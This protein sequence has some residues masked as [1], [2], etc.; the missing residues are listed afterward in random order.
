V[1]E[2]MAQLQELSDVASREFS[3]EK[4]LDKMAADW[5]GLA[6]ELGA[7][8]ATG[9]YILKGGPVDEAQTLLD[10]HIVKSQAMTASPFAKPFEARLV[11][12]E[13][14]LVRFQDILDQWLKCQGKWIYLEPIFSAEMIM[15]QIPT[16]GAA[17]KSM[18][19][20]WHAIMDKVVVNPNM[21]VVADID[22]LLE[23]LQAANASLDVVEKGLN[24][25]LDTKKM[26]F[27]RFY[28]LSN[29]ELLEILSEAKD[30][31]KIQPFVR[32]IFEAMKELQFEEGDMMTAMF[33]VEGEKV[34][35]NAGVDP[36]QSNAVEVWLGEVEEAMM[37]ALRKQ[38]RFCRYRVSPT[39]EL[40]YRG[41]RRVRTQCPLYKRSLIV[42]CKYVLLL[43]Y[44]FFYSLIPNH[45]KVALEFK[46]VA[47]K[48]DIKQAGLA[49][50]AYAGTDRNKW[51][52]EW[53]GQ[54]VL[55]CSQIYW[56]KEAADALDSE[57]AK[58]LTKYGQQCTQQL[59]DIVNLVRGDLTKL[60]RSTL[61]AL[62]TIDVHARDVTVSMGEEGVSSTTDFKWQSQLRYYMVDN[63][64]Q[65]CVCVCVCVCACVCVCVC[66]SGLLG[67]FL[68]HRPG[69]C[70]CRKGLAFVGPLI[71]RFSPAKAG[72]TAGQSSFYCRPRPAAQLLPISP[73]GNIN[74]IA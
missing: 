53:P 12:W 65:V 13:R 73:G 20:T 40:K 2:K 31:T 29:D 11:P 72:F 18:D 61:G 64:I 38:V 54:L 42:N 71:T 55:G 43:N 59:T 44:R 47:A 51:I 35:W 24:D 14:R 15:K 22:Q 50:D 28:F 3:F 33:S 36:H 41:A 39:D 66:V 7:W 37:Q 69:L 23:D 5:E 9:T 60:E 10:D 16:E 74:A 46:S 49:V 34:D 8:K 68:W 63:A 56:T 58:G 17:F 32:K 6:F 62:V 26:S 70:Q 67:S 30:P 52:L 1:E 19:A 21:L 25:F 45:K 48:S 57:G 27:P 4:M